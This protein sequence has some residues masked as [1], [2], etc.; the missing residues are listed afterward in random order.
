MHILRTQG[1]KHLRSYRRQELSVIGFL[2]G[3]CRLLLQMYW[4][5]A[6][7]KGI[8][9]LLISDVTL[10]TLRLDL[11]RVDID[12]TLASARK[13]TVYGV[14]DQVRLKTAFTATETK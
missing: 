2:N 12:H 6:S 5:R 4:L 1:V 9:R 8:L 10:I 14:R 11:I 3:N 7:R 13:K